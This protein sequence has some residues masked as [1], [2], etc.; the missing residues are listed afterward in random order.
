M[1]VGPDA[2]R[3]AFEATI[4]AT[5]PL[6]IDGVPYLKALGEGELD[7]QMLQGRDAQRVFKV[8]ALMDA[9]PNWWNGSL[10]HFSQTFRVQMLYHVPPAFGN[11]DTAREMA[12]SDAAR[13]SWALTMNFDVAAAPE[14]TDVEALSSRDLRQL[15][16]DCWLAEWEFRAGYFLGEE[17][18]PP[19]ISP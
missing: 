3:G 17:T 7:T 18:T 13:L 1:A 15:D 16:N 8:Y 9:V 11:G 5:E 6:I 12:G 4:E 2:V 10:G 14:L 19:E